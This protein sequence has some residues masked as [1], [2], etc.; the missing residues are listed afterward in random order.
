MKFETKLSLLIGANGKTPTQY[1]A[2]CLRR[3]AGK[4]EVLLI[5]SRDS[6]RWVLPKG[7][8]IAGL[9]A[10]GSAAREAW[11]EAGVIGT[12]SDTCLGHFSY[13]KTLGTA[14]ARPCRV[15][16]YPLSVDR[17]A[18]EFPEMGQRK[19]K[20]F[21]PSKAATKVLEPELAQLLAELPAKL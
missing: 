13:E 21:T 8:P 14:I 15:A 12:V 6:G 11:E 2:L 1:A 19:R 4:Q 7:W 20:W 16:V 5:T 9:G 3:R 18:D 17:L 10:S